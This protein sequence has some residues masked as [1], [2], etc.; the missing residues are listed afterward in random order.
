MPGATRIAG[1]SIK[2]VHA[3]FLGNMTRGSRHQLLGDAERA[4]LA[5]IS[6]IVRFKKG[7]AIYERGAPAIASFNIIDGIVTCY[8]PV[9]RRRKHIAAFLYPGDMFG[10]SEEGR[11][12][13]SARATTAV[14]AYKIPLAAMRR[15]LSRR[16]DLDVDIIVKLYDDLR[17]AQLHGFLLSQKRALTRVAMLLDMHECM[18]RIDGEPLLEIYLPMD[19]SAIADYLG[20][21]LP[22]VSRA[23]RTLESRKVVEFRNRRHVRILDRTAFNRIAGIQD[24]E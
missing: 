8:R 6:S 15:L 16:A 14:V 7:E 5:K 13:N 21:P 17:Q 19:R 22:A 9:Q 4:E 10:L 3:W 2:A 12:A 11:Y 24:L 20:L 23:F 1:P 18:Q